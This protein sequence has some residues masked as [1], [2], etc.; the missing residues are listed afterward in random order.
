MPKWTNTHFV[1][2]NFCQC[3]PCDDLE[4]GLPGIEISTQSSI[5]TK[6]GNELA[7]IEISSFL[8][9]KSWYARVPKPI[10]KHSQINEN[11]SCQK[12]ES[13]VLLEVLQSTGKSQVVFSHNRGTKNYAR[14]HQESLQKYA[15]V[16]KRRQIIERM[17][18]RF[19]S[20]P[21]ACIR[22]RSKPEQPRDVA[23]RMPKRSHGRNG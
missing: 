15:V 16:Q 21:E 19:P 12:T 13:T 7:N 2:N 22:W 6:P 23:E 9:S 20:K 14:F 18:E 17:L 1:S 3:I 10:S 5:K 11:L 4:V 8:N